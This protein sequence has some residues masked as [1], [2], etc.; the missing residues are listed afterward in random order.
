M[1]FLQDERLA[2]LADEYGLEIIYVPHPN[3]EPHL[4]QSDLPRGARLVRYADGDIQDVI[5][6]AAV[7]VTDYSSL[8]FEAA[9]LLIP[10]VYF[11]FDREQ[12]FAEHPHRPGYFDY[13]DDGFGRVVYDGRAAVEATAEAVSGST[14][15]EVYS[16][17]ARQFFAFRDGQCS[18]R[19][20]RAIS[21]IDQKNGQ[22]MPPALPSR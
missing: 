22:E 14:A 21:A 9:Y 13:E 7:L 11:Q 6:R 2:R 1:G 15:S 17:R 5:A 4:S 8:A 10:V 3:L 12:F 16:S 19:V 20:F 18:E